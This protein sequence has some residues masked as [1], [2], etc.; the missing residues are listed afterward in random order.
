MENSDSGIQLEMNFNTPSGNRFRSCL[1]RGVFT[2]L[3]EHAPPGRELPDDEAARRLEK[4]EKAVLAVKTMPCALALT[5]RCWSDERR[6]AVEYA[7]LLPE[8]NRNS[9]LV[10]LSGRNT[11]SDSMQGLLASAVSAG[12]A[13]LVVVSGDSRPDEDARTLRR[14]DFTESV[15]T[16][17]FIQQNPA[18]KNFFAGAAV[19]PNLYNAPAL[20]SSLFKLVKKFNM[21]AE[22]AVAQAGFDM[23]QLDAL[24]SYLFLREYN[25]PLI[26]R[27]MILTPEK[28]EK[29]IAGE[30]PGITISEDFLNILTKE[31]RFSESQFEA[32]QY[33]RLELQAAGCKLLGFGGIQICGAD[34]A[35]KIDIAA[36][37]IS[38]AMREFSNLSQWV[39]EYKFYMARSDIAPADEHFY[40]F[41]KLLSTAQFDETLP[42]LTEFTPPPQSWA[43]RWGGSLRKFFFPEADIQDAGERRWLK[44]LLAG[45]PGCQQCRLPQTFYHCPELCPK[46]LSNGP[47]GGVRHNGWCEAGDFPCVHL[48]IWHSAER[49]KCC[50]QLEND[51]VG[52]GS[53]C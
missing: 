21:G 45:C 41:E 12:I 51:F 14:M 35:E 4:L 17:R 28:V 40:L 48:A 42:P 47:C 27:L 33:R 34:T 7:A 24:R 30:L 31:L 10:Y 25:Q 3:F 53:D 13:N 44:K 39:E 16:L 52:S 15:K 1:E 11:D 46:A 20:Y 9:H 8:K 26:A 23:A 38:R 37:R 6:R 5:D 29:I 50:A 19:N 32:A 22:F 36:Q 43:Q 49:S 2:V 18:W